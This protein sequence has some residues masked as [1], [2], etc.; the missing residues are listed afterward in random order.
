MFTLLIFAALYGAWRAGRSA[1][2][3]LRGLPRSNDDW[4]YF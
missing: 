2:D 1:L 4:I 3:S